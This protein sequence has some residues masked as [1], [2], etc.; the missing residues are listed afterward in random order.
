MFLLLVIFL[1]TA[2]TYRIISSVII[3]FKMMDFANF[4]FQKNKISNLHILA[5]ISIHNEIKTVLLLNDN[6]T[7]ISCFLQINIQK[8]Q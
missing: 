2:K 7:I 8:G 6:N 5:N 3:P 4:H 1:T